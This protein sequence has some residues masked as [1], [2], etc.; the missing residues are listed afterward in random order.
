LALVIGSFAR[1]LDE[2]NNFSMAVYLVSCLFSGL[3]VNIDTMIWI[4]QPFKYL[5]IHRYAYTG[6]AINDLHGLDL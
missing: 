5:S 6:L 1:S 4:V 3:F 2:A